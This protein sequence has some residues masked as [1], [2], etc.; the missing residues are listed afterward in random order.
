MCSPC[1]AQGA[2]EKISLLCF[3]VDQ[4]VRVLFLS[5]TDM[6]TLLGVT[7]GDRVP[8]PYISCK[9]NQEVS[10]VTRCSLPGDLVQFQR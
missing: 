1:M 2:R 5:P 9:L 4:V 7:L 3:V 10:A 8:L 6:N